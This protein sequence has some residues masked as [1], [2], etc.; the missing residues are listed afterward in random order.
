MLTNFSLLG[1]QKHQ[2][3]FLLERDTWLIIINYDQP[4]LKGINYDDVNAAIRE[5]TLDK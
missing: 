3:F 1:E 5:C 2:V 4:Y